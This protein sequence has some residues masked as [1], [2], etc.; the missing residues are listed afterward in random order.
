MLLK[1]TSSSQVYLFVSNIRFILSHNWNQLRHC[2]LALGTPPHHVEALHGSWTLTAQTLMAFYSWPL[3]LH[4]LPFTSWFASWL[5]RTQ[6]PACHSFLSWILWVLILAK[7]GQYL[8][9]LSFLLS[10]S[11]LAST[12]GLTYPSTCTHSHT[13]TTKHLVPNCSIY[14]ILLLPKY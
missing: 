11:S 12:C 1:E 4:W 14:P 2:C 13:H 8:L 3:V 10:V 5:P 6:A 9:A 7:M